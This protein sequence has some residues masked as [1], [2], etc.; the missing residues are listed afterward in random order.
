MDP[1]PL[2]PE[3]RVSRVALH[4]SRCPRRARAGEGGPLSTPSPPQPS[5]TL[6][7][8][9][10]GDRLPCKCARGPKRIYPDGGDPGGHLAVECSPPIRRQMPATLCG[11][12]ACRVSG[13][14]CGQAETV[15]GLHLPG[16][17]GTEACSLPGV[18][19]PAMCLQGPSW[20]PGQ[21]PHCPPGGTLRGSVCSSHP[22]PS[23]K[24]SASP[25]PSSRPQRQ[26]SLSDL[27]QATSHLRPSVP[28][29]E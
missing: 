21:H 14:G 16:L 12:D 9:N 22:Y 11:Q 10:M 1:C 3:P 19:A 4:L 15:C 13:L 27:E 18:T 23:G 20:G 6:R 29:G 28:F 24:V 5:Q 25:S 7:N 8:A 26:L 17:A 2:N